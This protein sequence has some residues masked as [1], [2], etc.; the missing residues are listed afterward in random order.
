M[1]KELGRRPPSEL[2]ERMEDEED[3]EEVRRGEPVGEPGKR[4]CESCEL[5]PQIRR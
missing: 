5:R 1:S 2:V 3:I 4:G